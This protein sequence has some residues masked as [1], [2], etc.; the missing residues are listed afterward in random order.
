MELKNFERLEEKMATLIHHLRLPLLAIYF[1]EIHFYQKIS[2][3]YFF[4]QTC[5]KDVNASPPN[6]AP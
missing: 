6:M 5:V 4:N 2:A 3:N 1:K